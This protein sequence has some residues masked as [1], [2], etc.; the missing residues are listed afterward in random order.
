VDGRIIHGPNVDHSFGVKLFDEVYE[1]V[2][3]KQMAIVESV[4]IGSHR[5]VKEIEVVLGGGDMD[6]LQ[7]LN[8]GFVLGRR[9][10]TG[11]VFRGRGLHME[12]DKR[13]EG[14]PG[15]SL[16]ERALV[17]RA[18]PA[19]LCSGLDTFSLYFLSVTACVL[20]GRNGFSSGF[21]LADLTPVH[22]AV[23]G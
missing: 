2:S 1:G 3:F 11:I 7:R 16:S 17:K 22:E 10:R 15:V 6:R 5:G 8:D 9:V 20:A 23:L 14:G 4:E 19:R 13:Q 21:P 18:I 12:K